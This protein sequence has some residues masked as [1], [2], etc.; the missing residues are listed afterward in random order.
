M[1]S[2]AT[3]MAVIAMSVVASPECASTGGNVVKRMT[4]S[5]AAPPPKYDFVHIHTTSVTMTKK[6]RTPNLARVRF[7]SYASL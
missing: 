2:A 1:N 5:K 4:D 6:G 7:R 3:A